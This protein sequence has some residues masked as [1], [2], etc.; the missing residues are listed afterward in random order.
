MIT[1]GKFTLSFQGCAVQCTCTVNYFHDRDKIR[2][3]KR[4]PIAI[5]P[6]KRNRFVGGAQCA[7]CIKNGHYIIRGSLY[8]YL[9]RQLTQ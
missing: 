2:A 6:Q 8:N 7:F 9:G 3:H 5:S 4:Q 1:H